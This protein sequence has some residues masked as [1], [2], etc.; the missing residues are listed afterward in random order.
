[1]AS[2]EALVSDETRDIGKA[3][4]QSG[5]VD[6]ETRF[7]SADE[8]LRAGATHYFMQGKPVGRG[9]LDALDAVR[10]EQVPCGPGEVGVRYRIVGLDE[11]RAAHEREIIEAANTG[12]LPWPTDR[13]HCSCSARAGEE[14][15]GFCVAWRRQLSRT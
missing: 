8:M 4:R 13:E 5:L 15:R 9:F 2:V 7:G 10:M 1:M 6:S 3:L 12:S 11:V 14:H